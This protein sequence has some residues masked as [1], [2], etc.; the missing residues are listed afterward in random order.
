ARRELLAPVEHV[1]H[2][3]A[4]GDGEPSATA[5]PFA[6]RSFDAVLCAEALDRLAD[7][8]ATLREVAR[9]LKP[10]GWL[11]VATTVVWGPGGDGRTS[12]ELETALREAG[13]GELAIAPSA[14]SLV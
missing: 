2:E 12:A 13:F 8:V 14:T 1:A 4:Q 10:E 7:P 5:L 3:L 11:V 9:V 6:D